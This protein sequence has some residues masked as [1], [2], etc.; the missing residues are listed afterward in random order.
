MAKFNVLR[1]VRTNQG[2]ESLLRAVERWEREGYFLNGGTYTAAAVSKH[3]KRHDRVVIL[4][5]EQAAGGSVHQAVPAGVPIYT[6]NLA[7][8]RAGHTPDQPGRYTFGGLSDGAFA[9]VPLI[10]AGHAEVWPF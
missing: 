5:D 3:F 4:T 9:L 8:Y 10:E 1:R 2:G 6:W 7:G